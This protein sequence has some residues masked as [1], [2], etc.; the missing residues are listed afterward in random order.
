MMR[1]QITL[2]AISESRM[3]VVVL[4]AHQALSTMDL[5]LMRIICSVE[6]REVLIF[7]NRID[8]L[9]DPA[10]DTKRIERDIRRTLKRLGLGAELPILFGSGYWANCA[11][12]DRCDDMMPTSR[13]G[14]DVLYP[15][16]DF[17]DPD[18]LRRK[19]MDA[20]GIAVLHR[21][22]AN[23]VVAGPGKALIADI[24]A[25]LSQVEEMRETVVSMAQTGAVVSGMVSADEVTKKL[26]EL[27]ETHARR[28]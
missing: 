2:S 21:V 16:A 17:S 5:A 15:D 27:G 18:T 12:D 25:E 14:L 28:L 9:E 7:V 1:E 22:V 23:R 26:S 19:A 11:L 8:E 10:E 3:C 24:E 4:S 20:S 6:S 13:A